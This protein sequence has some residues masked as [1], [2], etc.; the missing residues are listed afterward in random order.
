MHVIGHQDVSAE[1]KLITGAVVVE[2]FQV[3][4]PI[5]IGTEDHLALIA[6]RDQMVKRTG[7]MNSRFSRHAISVITTTTMNAKDK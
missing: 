6:T 3:T 5:G 4:A 1:L 2:Q 7:K